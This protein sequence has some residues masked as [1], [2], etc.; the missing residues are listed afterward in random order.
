MVPLA[1]TWLAG[2]LTALAI[3]SFFTQQAFDRS[4]LDDA[5]LMAANVK[6]HDG[7]LELSLTPR[8]VN[9]VLFDQV[10]SV[11]FAV[12]QSDGTLVAGNPDLHPPRLPD[13]A[14]YR[15][16]DFTYRGRPL[17]TVT[18]HRDEPAAF[19][20]VMAQTTLSRSTLLQRLLMYSIG[21]QLVL[22]LLLALWL[23][24][25]IQRDLQPLAQLQQAVDQRDAHDL[26]FV[27]VSA[28]TRD[29]ER[30][31]VAVNSLLGRLDQSA[32]TQREFAGNIA[33]ELRT[34]L[35]GIRALAEY[36]LA[37]KDPQAWRVQLEGIASSQARASR[38]VD[39]LL[40]LAL[41]DEANPGMR[42]EAIALDDMVR[43]AVLRFLPRADAANV[44]LG[45]RGAE[46]PVRVAADV[47]LVEG[48]LNNLIDN[49]LRYGLDPASA[50][51]S[52]TVALAQERSGVSLAV[53]DNG[54]GLP[55]DM[56]A[57]L[58]QR[59]AQGEAGHTLGQGAGLGLPIVAQYARLMN[60]RFELG[61]GPHGRGL[62][63]SVT[64]DAL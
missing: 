31:G 14:V 38:L 15:F 17:R 36:G 29:V 18:L 50:T 7:K 16:A 24:G 64:F 20:V 54:P 45:A 11:F 6:L 28:T 59:W 47:T 30:L 9:T 4:L 22:L 5:Y 55:E 10:E 57:R 35:A 8:E 12:L 53:I 33:H 1:L 25:T 46:N 13:A 49:A 43:D 34:P 40:A 42:L 60:A 26:T 51:T 41:A 23:R 21:P 3:A 62:V 32:R 37:Q 58:T 44:D 2:T 56:R 27:P 19:D 52:V 39:Q 48:I 63:A 61:T